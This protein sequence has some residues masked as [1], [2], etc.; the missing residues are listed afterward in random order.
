MGKFGSFMDD[1]LTKAKKTADYVGDKTGDAVETGKIKYQIKQVEWNIDKAYT[2]LGQFYYEQKKGG[3]DFQEIIDTAVDEID[4]LKIKHKELTEKILEYK[5]AVICP[6]CGTENDTAF[7]FC[8]K[9]GARL[10][11]Y[12][13]DEEPTE[14]DDGESAQET[15]NKVS[16]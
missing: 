13:P 14:A 2:K 5:N 11:K 4:S 9:C 16:E 12:E 6:N 10:P 3:T 1:V 7:A 8:V 15:E